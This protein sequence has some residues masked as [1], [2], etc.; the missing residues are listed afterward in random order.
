MMIEMYLSRKSVYMGNP[1]ID[2]KENILKIHH[3]VAS[4]KLFGIDKEKSDYDIHS[5]A[6]SGFGVTLRHDFSK[7]KGEVVTIG[8]FNPSGTKMIVTK[9]E[10]IGGSGLEGCGC[11]QNVE[12]KVPN[13]YEL[14]REMQNFGHHQALVYGD[15]IE[16][17]RDLGDM[18]NFEVIPVI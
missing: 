3:S 13:A 16:N 15:Y 11:A 7:S 8:R 17:I 18:M 10:I 5:F 14:W 2:K 4:L 12:I 9:G 6:E 1:D